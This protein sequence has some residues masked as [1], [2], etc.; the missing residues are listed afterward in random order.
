VEFDADAP[1]QM[2]AAPTEDEEGFMTVTRDLRHKEHQP[3]VQQNAWKAPEP[4]KKHNRFSDN[5]GDN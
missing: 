5:W 3:R 4:S 2:K 1:V